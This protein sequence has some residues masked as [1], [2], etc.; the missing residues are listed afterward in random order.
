MKFVCSVAYL[1]LTAGEFYLT[2]KSQK[3]KLDELGGSQSQGTRQLLHLACNLHKSVRAILA[4]DSHIP[5]SVDR[6]AGSRVTVGERYSFHHRCSS[7]VY[8]PG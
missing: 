5:G 3:F 1:L 4:V 7:G 8:A 6:S 2:S